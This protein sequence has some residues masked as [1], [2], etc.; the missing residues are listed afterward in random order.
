MLVVLHSAFAACP[1]TCEGR[2]AEATW[3]A[4]EGVRR[5][6]ALGD[7]GL[8]ALNQSIL[9]YCRWL[10]GKVGEVVELCE[11]IIEL[12]AGGLAIPFADSAVDPRIW[13]HIARAPS[14]LALGRVEEANAAMARGLE[15]AAEVDEEMLGWAHMFAATLFCIDPDLPVDDLVEHTR[16]SAEIADRLGDAFSRAW[17]RFWTAYAAMRAGAHDEAQEGFTRALEQMQDLGAGRE[18]ETL[19]RY[20]LGATLVAAGHLDE[21]IASGRRA[22]EIAVD[23]GLGTAELWGSEALAGW[24]LDR[25]G[26]G[27]FEEAAE[28]LAAAADLADRTGNVLFAGR[29]AEVRSRLPAIT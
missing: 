21:G 14:L 22:V 25:G 24:L 17:A 1:L 28:L 19:L 9:I 15:L 29:I 7:P 27:D 26:S 2:L 8:K 3:I 20:G 4:S 13:A 5:A 11:E 6:E 23:L 16:R 18:S 10:E 12:T